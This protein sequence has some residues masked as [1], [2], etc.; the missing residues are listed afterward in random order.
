MNE[1]L[2]ELLKY[3]TPTVG[4]I[5]VFV[6]LIA[7]NPEK[8]EIWASIFNKILS[9]LG[10]V[11]K[12]AHRRYV[13]HDLQGRINSFT[14]EVSKS[15]PYFENTKI[16]IEF[17]DTH[18]DKKAF[19]AEGKAVIR[20]RREDPD[21]LNF[22]HGSY[23]AVATCLLPKVKR[24]I[25]P[26]QRQALDLYV[27]QSIIKR[28][29]VQVIEHFL[30]QYLHPGFS[31]KLDGSQEKIE[32]LFEQFTKI[33][34]YGVFYP[35]LL[36]ELYFLSQK[37]YGG[38]K[39][40]QIISEASRLIDFLERVSGRQIGQDMELEFK[41]EYCRFAI[42]IVGKSFKVES[43]EHEVYVKYIHKIKATHNLETVYVLGKRENQRF[44][45]VV[46]G[47]LSSEFEIYKRHKYEGELSTQN[48]KI[49]QKG[50]LV[51]VRCSG[52]E[53]YQ[54]A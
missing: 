49:R 18:Q 24:Y 22:V 39:K 8:V 20:L 9:S 31:G 42:V 5:V 25:S 2:A 7:L 33:D 19:L 12:S 1:L 37:V 53:L 43:D 27:T 38:P 44:I 17:I 45:D 11:F 14:K 47:E 15:A 30:D 34:K 32:R 54:S 50:Y 48:G 29:K 4:L 36:Q 23:W 21:D 35:L 26:S 52:V 10:G 28:E 41:G 51:V 40:E 16:A 46:C 3:L 13:K 6:A